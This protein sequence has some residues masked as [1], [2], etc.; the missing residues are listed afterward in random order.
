MVG[1]R[2]RDVDEGGLDVDSAVSDTAAAAIASLANETR[3]RILLVLWDADDRPLRFG[4]L[5]ERVGM[6]DPGQFRYHL[7]KL[8]DQFVRKTPEGYDIANAGVN[9]VWAIRSGDLTTRADV[10]SFSF[11]LDSTCATCGATLTLRSEE[12][13]LAVTCPSCGQQHE[14]TP[15]HPSGLVGR[16][17]DEILATY[18]QVIRTQHHLGAH[19]ICPRCYGSGSFEV[20][21]DESLLPVGLRDSLSADELAELTRYDPDDGKVNVVWTCS[22]CG[23]WMEFPLGVLLSYRLEVAKFY[24]DHGVDIDSISA[25]ELPQYLGDVQIT[26]TETTPLSLQVAVT[27]DDETL[28]ISVEEGFTAITTER[29]PAADSSPRS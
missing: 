17:E 20:S 11:P 21:T 1:D 22:Q 7:R 26:V 4:E 27:L 14:M 29:T 10:G 3:L 12:Q 16:T 18:E 28:T 24:R 8:E 6:R 19:D 2:E 15:F 9:V 13:M 25:R 5:R 23:L